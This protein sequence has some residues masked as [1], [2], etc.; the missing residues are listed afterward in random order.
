MKM[1]TTRYLH[2]M[3]GQRGT[4]HHKAKLSNTD[5]RN[6]RKMYASGKWTHQAL[7]K[8]Y[9]MSHPTIGKLI[10]GEIWTTVK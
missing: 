1:T 5:V 8:K 6:I 3:K 7:A 2:N 9:G 4:D 10:R